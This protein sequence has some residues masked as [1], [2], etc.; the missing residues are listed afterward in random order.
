MYLSIKTWVVRYLT[1]EVSV[2]TGVSEE[3]VQSGEHCVLAGG[4]AIQT[5]QRQRQA[6]GPGQ[7]DLQHTH[8]GQGRRPHQ[9]RAERAATGGETTG[10]SQQQYL[11]QTTA[12]G[13]RHV[14]FLSSALSWFY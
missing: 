13:T 14:L 2:Y 11:R 3:G 6:Q 12:R 9:H 4:R 1:S 7:G 10:L 8:L 5:D